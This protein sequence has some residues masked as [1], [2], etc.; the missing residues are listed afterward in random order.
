M[1]IF[2]LLRLDPFCRVNDAFVHDTSVDAT[3]LT[4][5]VCH[6][7]IVGLPND[8][9]TRFQAEFYK[10]IACD[11]VVETVLNYPYPYVSEKTLRPIACKRMF[12]ICGPH[13][14]LSLLRSKGFVTFDD[15]IDETYDQELDPIKRFQAVTQEMRNLCTTPLSKIVQYLHDNQSRL[16]HNFETLMQLQSQELSELESRLS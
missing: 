5:S 12:V 16:D 14:I 6:P 8:L 2:N 9:A 13:G 10:N 1:P 7:M 11:F 15:F 3:P 4:E